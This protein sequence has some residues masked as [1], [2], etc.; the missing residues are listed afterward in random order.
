MSTFERDD[1]QWRETY[2]VTFA[3][4]GRPTRAEVESALGAVG[5]CLEIENLIGDAEGNFETVT[6]RS[7]EDYSAIDVSYVC[8]E[9]I[10]EENNRI[11]EELGPLAADDEERKKA[12]LLPKLDARFDV[13]HFEQV[14][15]GDPT[16]DEMGDMLDPSAL[17]MVLEALEHLTGGIAIDPQSGAFVA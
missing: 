15:K 7:S 9:E 14:V 2:F 1:Y 16:G 11:A 8:G 17:L 13:M 6:L 3:A 12:G 5:V 4:S 10:V